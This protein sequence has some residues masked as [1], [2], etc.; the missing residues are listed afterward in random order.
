MNENNPYKNQLQSF[1]KYAEYIRAKELADQMYIDGLLKQL[2]EAKAAS[3]GNELLNE[4]MELK[5]QLQP[6]TKALTHKISDLKKVGKKQAIIEKFRAS[7][8]LK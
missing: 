3:Q 7:Q 1:K 4:I 8:L 2:I 6:L 5:E